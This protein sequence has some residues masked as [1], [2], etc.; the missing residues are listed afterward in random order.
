[1]IDIQIGKRYAEAIYEISEEKNK[2]KEVYELLSNVMELYKI[3]ID[4]KNFI[5]SPLINFEE[6]IL[7]LKEIFSSTDIETLDIL[8]YILKKNRIE[9]IR[10][11]VAEFLKIHYR[12]NRIL[13]VK[14]IF[15]REL[16]EEQ[17]DKLIAKLSQ[18]TGKE[19]NLEVVVDKNILGG[20]ILKIGDKVIDGSIRRDLENWKVTKS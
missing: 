16:S 12:K 15:T 4:F 20:G 14:A 6:K 13:D 7:T 3:D 8:F 5:T 1:M 18:K 2:I 11:I 10:E 19:I 9:A 17:K